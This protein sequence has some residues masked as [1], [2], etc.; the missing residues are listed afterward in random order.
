MFEFRDLVQEM[1]K[2]SIIAFSPEL[3][4]RTTG[5]QPVNVLSSRGAV[6]GYSA[7]IVGVLFLKLDLKFFIPDRNL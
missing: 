5:A 6:A 1:A 3:L 2:V 7:T 4:P